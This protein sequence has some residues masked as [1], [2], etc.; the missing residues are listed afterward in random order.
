MFS[1][2]HCR[3]KNF[4]L[5]KLHIHT[6]FL[7][8]QLLY[9]FIFYGQSKWGWLIFGIL[10]WGLFKVMGFQILNFV[11]IIFHS[12]LILIKKFYQTQASQWG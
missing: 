12:L 3:S 6:R 2:F 10:G 9:Y 5:T 1:I 8:L 4:E 7:F 11:V